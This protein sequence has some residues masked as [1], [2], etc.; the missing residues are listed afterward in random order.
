[1]AKGT[2]VVA[3]T[4][5]SLIGQVVDYF[6]RHV[7]QAT[8]IPL[9]ILEE[10]PNGEQKVILFKKTTDETLGEEGYRLTV[11]ST[12]ILLKANRPAGLFYGVQT[13]FQLLPSEIF[14]INDPQNGSWRV[15]CVTILDKPRYPW[16]GLMLDVSRHFFPKEFVKKQIDYLAMHKMNRLHLHLTDDQGWRIEI[17]KYPKLTQISSWRR[18]A[19]GRITGGYYTQDD[20]REL[21]AYAQSRFVTIV[22]E[23]EMP[24]HCQ[25]ALAAYPQLSCTGGPFHVATEWGVHKDVYCAGND[26]TFAFLENVLSEVIRLFPSPYIHVGGDEVPK[27]RWKAC[28]KCQARIQA[29]GLKDEAELQSYFIRRI[30]KFLNAHGKRLIGWDEILEGGLAPNAIVMSW[31]GIQGGIAAAKQQHDVVM[32][33]T[34][35]CY[36]DYY[37]GDPKTEPLAIGGN[38]PIEKVYQFDPTPKALSPEEAA[39]ILGGQANLWTEYIATP[40][41]A[42]YMTYPRLAAMAEVLWSPKEKRNW[43]DFF[44]RLLTQFKRYDVLGI[45]YARSLFAVNVKSELEVS[46]KQWRVTLKPYLSEMEVRYTLDGSEPTGHSNVYKKPLVLNCT[47]TLK[48][49]TFVNGQAVGSTVQRTFYRHKALG[50]QV[51]VAFPYGP[52]YTAGG[53]FALTDGLL[54]TRYFR[55][56]RWQGYDGVDFVGTI[57]LGKPVSVHKISVRFLQNIS[58]WI[59]LP[60][61]VAFSVSENGQQFEPIATLKNWVSP[62]VNDVVVKPFTCNCS[63]KPVRW[64]RVEAK[65]RGVCPPWH[66]GAGGKA[67]I[68]LDEIR[69]D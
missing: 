17:K 49:K 69:V 53:D 3:D 13:L 47:A 50:Q 61:S 62:R 36:F 9:H 14:A 59:F 11:R 6:A 21:V 22:P 43:R 4:T 39:H 23:I 45:H 1:L 15:P 67:W 24:G 41:H 34:S 19:D 33:P 2:S 42:E 66:P 58:S 26:S 25:A 48:V 57:D 28:S 40:E 60:T 68:F 54:G 18:E 52:R 38:L 64:V 16:R 56:G 7:Q 46:Q 27:D 44:G 8:G 65:N 32:T 30:E 5:D 51:S 55:D 63:G 12:Q 29:E 35:S 10:P 20:I 31:R 37:Q